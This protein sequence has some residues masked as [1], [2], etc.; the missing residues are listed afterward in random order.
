MAADNHV[1]YP[2]SYEEEII[3][4]AD[5]DVNTFT[6]NSVNV[7]CLQRI[8]VVHLIQLR[9]ENKSFKN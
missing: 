6:F 3:H 9:D 8:N 5:V 7:F 2:N 1:I 4:G